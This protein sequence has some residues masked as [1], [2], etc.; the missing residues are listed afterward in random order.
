M[1]IRTYSKRALSVLLIAVILV[2]VFAVAITTSIQNAQART[3]DALVGKT[4]F[5]SEFYDYLYDSE[6][7]NSSILQGVAQSYTNE[8]FH[9]L[10]NT[11]SDYYETNDV[12]TPIY[13]GNF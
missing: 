9:M 5:K 4:T 8:P 3:V 11:A 2:S 1:K 12:N 6:I 7:V 10:N 13:F